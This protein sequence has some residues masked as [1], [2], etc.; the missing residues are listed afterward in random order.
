MS[1]PTSHTFETVL[2]VPHYNLSAHTF[3]IHTLPLHWISSI[4]DILASNPIVTCDLLVLDQINQTILNLEQQLDEQHH[5]AAWQFSI[6]LTHQSASWIP[7]HIHDIKQ[8][9][10]WHCQIWQWSQPII[11]HGSSSKSDSLSSSSSIQ[12]Q[13]RQMPSYPHQSP[14]VPVASTSTPTMSFPWMTTQSDWVLAW[15]W[16]EVNAPDYLCQL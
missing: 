15:T 4:I 7:Q 1:Q 12:E 16:F 14:A 13:Y 6:L 2:S 3:A 11:I 9:D 10:C 8:P 5:L